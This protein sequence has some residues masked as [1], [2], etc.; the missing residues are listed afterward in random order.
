MSK[1][2]DA[3][4]RGTRGADWL[5]VKC[6]KQQE[7][8]I[9]GYTEPEGSR[10]GIGALLGRVYESGRLVYVGKIGTGFDNRTLAR[11]A[12]A[13][14]VASS[15]RR[16]RS[17]RGRPAPRAHWVKPELVGQVSFS[18]WTSDG[19]LRHPAFQ[20]LRE[21]KPAD[22]VVG[23]ARGRRRRGERNVDANAQARRA[24]A[25]AHCVG[26]DHRRGHRRRRPAHARRPDPLSAAWHDQARP[27]AVLQSRSPSGSSRTSRIAPPPSCAVRSGA[28]KSSA[29]TRST[30]A[31]GR[32]RA[33]DESRFG[34]SARSE[35]IWWS[36]R[37]R[38]SSAWSDRDPRDHTWNS[39]VKRLEQPDR[40]V[41]DLDP[42]PGVEWAPRHRVRPTH[43]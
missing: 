19:K 36:T 26:E 3:P 25:S 29:S 4:Y 6:L 2:R 34:R 38:R 13:S 32:Q 39:V 37:W 8:V 35:N 28:H 22:S 43:P 20:G 14:L 18:E 9:G 12:A 17:P 41:F 5:K 24:G 31:T 10:I 1:K 40:M 21:D 27:G 7:I 11:S 30:S 16:A 15:R 42:G 23:S 33:C